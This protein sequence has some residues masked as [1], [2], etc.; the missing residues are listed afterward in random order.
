MYCLKN[1]TGPSE[2]NVKIEVD[3]IIPQ[4]LFKASTIERKTIVQ[5]NLL[6]LGLLPKRENITKSNKRLSEITDPWMIE[7]IRR[8]EFISRNDFALYSDVSNY[9]QMFENR[10]SIYLEAFG[11]LRTMLLNN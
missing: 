11:E 5:D 6:N 3:H 9:Q 10:R 2:P 4:A 8:Y 7:Q 1:I